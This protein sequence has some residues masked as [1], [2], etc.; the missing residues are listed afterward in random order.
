MTDELQ[1]TER[2][3]A[4]AAALRAD[5]AWSVRR[6]DAD[7][8]REEGRGRFSAI[9]A[10]DPK[11]GLKDVLWRVFGG[12]SDD[13]ILAN[14]AAVTFYVLLAVFPAIAALVSIYGLFANPSSIAKQLDAVS[15]VLPGGAIEVVRD[16]LTRL[17][18]HG[19]AGLGVGF[20]VGLGASLWSANG[21]VKALFDALNT[22]YE[23]KEE[24]S[25]LKLNA[26]TLAF[27]VAMIGLLVVAL[28]GIVAIP[29][30]LKYLPDFVGQILDIARWPLLAVLVA[31][32]FAF[33]YR[34][35]ASRSE[36]EWRWI[37]WGSV[38]AALGWLAVS[39]LFSYYA[40]NYGTFNKTYGSLGAVIGF[41]LWIWLSVIVI[42]L[43]GKLNAVIE[44]RKPR[45]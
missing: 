38:S 28:A 20:A 5:G 41:M 13:R 31:V 45:S 34:Y 39:A 44:R 27:T 23:E 21:G 36:A 37:S 32:A 8:P 35:G 25:F 6:A 15:G 12:I 11:P 26:V 10:D 29:I 17:T 7:A 19:G 2:R 9:P 22:V 4:D 14:A 24:R 1:S 18:L 30:A 42:L 43:G 16:Q 40:A 3:A 33:I